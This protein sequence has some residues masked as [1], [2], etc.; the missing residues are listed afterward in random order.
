MASS[1][2]SARPPQKK[3]RGAAGNLLQFIAMSV[4]AGFVVAGLLIPPAAT[5]GLTGTAS[6][7]W[8]KGLPDDLSEGPLSQPSRILAKDGTEL[9]TFYAENRKE[10][11]LDEI[12][13]HM[14]DAQ[15]AIEDRDFYEHG[16][17]DGFGI[18]RAAYPLL[19]QSYILGGHVRIGLEDA[20]FIAKGELA[21]SNAALVEKAAWIVRN[22]GGE[23]ASADEAREMLGLAGSKQLAAAG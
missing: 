6:L 13:P 11:P 22:L 8:F 2:K 10:V 12:S 3:R 19:A 5:M 18:G 16:G 23:L 21:P 17:I 4:V 15:L 14:I 7:N 1:K 20:V 9:A